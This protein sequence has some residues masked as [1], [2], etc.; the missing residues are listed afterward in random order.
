MTQSARTTKLVFKT[1]VE[2]LVWM[3][4]LVERVQNVSQKVIVLFVD[5]PLDGVVILQLN[6]INVGLWSL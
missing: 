5:V 4:V 3:T 2:I 6:A 1:N